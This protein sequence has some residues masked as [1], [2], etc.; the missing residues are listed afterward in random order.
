M[1]PPFGALDRSVVSWAPVE[2]KTKRHVDI[3]PAPQHAGTFGAGCRRFPS[4][5]CVTVSDLPA[6]AQKEH[7]RNLNIGNISLLC[8][9]IIEPVNPIFRQIALV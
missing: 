9:Q 8:V 5:R 1:L 6:R 3:G 7:D 4:C 2:P